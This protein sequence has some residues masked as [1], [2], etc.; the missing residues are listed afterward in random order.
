M[1]DVSDAMF[2][3]VCRCL[4]F[5]LKYAVANGP[6]IHCWWS[7]LPADNKWF[8]LTLGKLMKLKS[9]NMFDTIHVKLIKKN[10]E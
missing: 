8:N 1:H 9:Q 2:L 5:R 7:Q 10:C 6:K 4:V 3:N